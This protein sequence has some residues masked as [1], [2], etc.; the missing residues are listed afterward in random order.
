MD[1]IAL[2][3]HSNACRMKASIL[4]SPSASED[5]KVKLV[6]LQIKGKAHAP[7]ELTTVIYVAR[8]RGF[9]QASASCAQSM[10]DIQ[11]VESG[12]HD[13]ILMISTIA[14]KPWTRR[15]AWGF[16]QKEIPPLHAR[17]TLVGELVRRSCLST[18]WQ[19][20]AQ[21]P[22]VSYLKCSVPKTRIIPTLLNP[23]I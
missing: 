13:A 16:Q 6:C 23:G 17:L 1:S 3:Y 19:P 2:Q 9:G 20:L 5:L 7:E 4:A 8:E 10:L 21:V 11:P 14:S 15:T 12:L 18:P 22:L